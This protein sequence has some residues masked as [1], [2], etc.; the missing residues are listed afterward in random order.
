MQPGAIPTIWASLRRVPRMCDFCFYAK[1]SSGK[2]TWLTLQYYR[3]RDVPQRL[4]S[5]TRAP[6][7]TNMVD[8]SHLRDGVRGST[9]T[10][11][12]R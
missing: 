1:L 3:L 6:R 9:A 4:D 10:F 12:C 8:G 7:G 2:R 5:R 11:T